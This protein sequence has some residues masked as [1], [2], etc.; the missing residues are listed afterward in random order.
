MPPFFLDPVPARQRQR[1]HQQDGLLQLLGFN[2]FQ[3]SKNE[4]NQNRCDF[5]MRYLSSASLA[6]KKY[7]KE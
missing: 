2:F 1:R 5:L 4:D 6:L 7:M 3:H